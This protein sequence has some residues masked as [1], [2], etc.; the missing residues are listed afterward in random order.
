MSRARTI[1]DKARVLVVPVMN[2]HA[3]FLSARTTTQCLSVLQQTPSYGKDP[4]F[5][6][7]T[8]PNPYG[9]WEHTTTGI[10]RGRPGLG[11]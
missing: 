4:R 8:K 7:L 9:N 3:I 10:P 1:L 5:A 2:P 11:W 6:P